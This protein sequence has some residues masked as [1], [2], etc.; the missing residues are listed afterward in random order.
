MDVYSKMTDEELAI[1]YI[2]GDNNAFDLLLSRNQQR[3]YSY[4]LFVV[5]DSEMAEDVFQD[6]FVK[7]IMRLQSGQYTSCGKFSAWIMRIAHNV[8]MDYYR[9]QRIESVVSTVDNEDLSQI[10]GRHV[11]VPNVESRYVNEQVYT[12][13]RHMMNML[14]PVQREVI[15]MRF[16]QDLSFKEIAE[17]TN[18][19]IN[20]ALGRMRYAV[21]NLRRMAKS[22]GV[23]LQLEQ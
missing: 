16:F 2:K 18:V 17:A 6:T 21:F 10:D 22:H 3:L 4:I 11:I 8:I 15:F 7:V 12:D 9:D 5:H 23:Y 20:T 19:S 1:A 13:V 14:P